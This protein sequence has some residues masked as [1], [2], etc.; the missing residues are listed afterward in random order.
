MVRKII[1]LIISIFL[2]INLS[3]CFALFAGGAIGATGTAVWL[4]G[5]LV[6]RVD[7]PLDKTINATKD[8]LRSMR[9]GFNSKENLYKGFAQVRSYT[10]AKEKI[11]ID[12]FRMADNS[13]QIQIRVGLRNK[14]RAE[15]I[16]R[17]IMQSF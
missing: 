8:A 4:S 15:M 14:E 5:K 17:A 7:Y 11:W 3:G 9:L 10:E 12:I 13:S 1:G 6:Q 16:L 2:L